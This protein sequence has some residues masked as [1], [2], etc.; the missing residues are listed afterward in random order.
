[1]I[2]SIRE[3]PFP[4]LPEFFLGEGFRILESTDA[5]SGTRRP[6]LE[7]TPDLATCPVCEA[8]YVEKENRRHGFALN[9]CT[10]C[11]PRFTIQYGAPFDRAR[12]AM[13]VFT[14]CP[15][16]R[17]EY[18]T[19]EDR[20][21]HAQNTSCPRCGPRLWLELAGFPERAESNGQVPPDD[22]PA[23][24]Q[25]AAWLRQGKIVAVMGMGGFH[26]LCDATEASVVEIL[27]QRKR[28][29]SKPFAVLFEDL[30][31]IDRHAHLDGTVRE[32]L[33]S[34]VAPIVLLP[35]RPESRL[36]PEIA[37]GLSTVG[38]MRPYSLIHRDLVRAAGRP[39]VA[40]SANASAEPMPIEP[41]RARAELS[42][43]ADAFLFHNRKIVRHA[44]DS[45]VRVI[46]GRPVPLR[47]GRGL[48][49]VR[50]E[51]PIEMPPLLALGA[52][53]KT[54]VA[55]ARGREI[56]LG[57][58]IGDLE[59][60]SLRQRF[61]ETV[62]DFCHL[63]GV[64]P[65][66]AICDAHPDYFTTRFAE[67]LGLPA[68]AVQH[69]QAHIA[70]CLAEHG[71]SGPVLGIAWDGTGL[72]TDGGTWGGEFLRVEGGTCQRL[73]S[74][75]PFPLVGGDRAAREPRRSAAG[76]CWAAGM[77]LKSSA[78]SEVEFRWLNS[79]LASASGAAGCT[80][81]G[82]LFD[83]WAFFLGL[84]DR[85]GYE[86]EPPIRL[87]DL[88]YPAEKGTFTIALVE[89][90]TGKGLL[91]IDWREWVRET[92]N[93]LARGTAPSVLAAR[94]HNSLVAASLEVARRLGLHT[95]VLSG[96]CF[97]NRWLSER[98]EQSLTA[99]GFRVLTHRRVPPGDGGLAVGQVWS[100]A[101][102]GKLSAK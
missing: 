72:G 94:F 101:L 81:A 16:C 41:E 6:G 9:A 97:Q 88:A 70:S 91:R 62:A 100:A 71:E 30:A 35:R 68:L 5:Q 43:I 8:E 89:E 76:V 29:E 79:A 93:S 80:S 1:L 37:P 2:Q 102:S 96:G 83:A 57:Q 95:V 64:K 67:D 52:H 10:D 42:G 7:I 44:D 17:H 34:A 65:Q 46:G 21:F 51:V 50:L 63:L 13:Q 25:A 38:A 39:L 48:A 11:G 47:V 36:A 55:L 73:A 53:L 32:A 75:W 26:L 20:R 45:V 28:R 24:Q 3:E 4:A 90:S 49:P 66:F 58:H 99:E 31:Q 54:A 84:G 18:E 77:P 61:R 14:L 22:E 15:D 86:G 27:R 87:E 59:T 40:T 33:A 85:A 23:L 74:L 12:T 98:L 92:Q 82:R 19:P 60:P 69:H 56:V 78:F